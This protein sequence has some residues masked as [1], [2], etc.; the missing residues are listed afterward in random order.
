M[1][2]TREAKGVGIMDVIFQGGTSASSASQ[3]CPPGVAT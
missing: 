2:Y 1:K 3:G